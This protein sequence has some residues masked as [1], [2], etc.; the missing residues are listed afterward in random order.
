MTRLKKTRRTSDPTRSD[1][2]T[3]ADKQATC[4]DLLPSIRLWRSK[5]ERARQSGPHT[6]GRWESISQADSGLVLWEKY[7]LGKFSEQQLFQ[8]FPK[9]YM[10]PFLPWIGPRLTWALLTAIWS[11]QEERK[12][13]AKDFVDWVKFHFTSSGGRPAKT[14][15]YKMVQQAAILRA[16]EWSWMKIAIRLCPER[17]PHHSCAERC[18]DK[19]RLAVKELQNQS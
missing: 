2:K 9:L 11:A 6:R 15:R 10:A 1:G 5:V 18:A 3:T 14:E 17:G 19:I 16:K 7:C 4:G 8:S 13:T 12:G